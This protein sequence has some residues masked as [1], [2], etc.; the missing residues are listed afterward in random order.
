[1]DLEVINRILSYQCELFNKR[2]IKNK[3]TTEA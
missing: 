1:M 3:V 2:T